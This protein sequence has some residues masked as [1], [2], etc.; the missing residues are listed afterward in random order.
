M[1]LHPYAI[2]IGIAIGF[3]V[4]MIL[5]YPPF[6]LFFG[7]IAVVLLDMGFKHFANKNVDKE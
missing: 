1:K 4:Q 2:I 5:R 7:I 6:A 3:L